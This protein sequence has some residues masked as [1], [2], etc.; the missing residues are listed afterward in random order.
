[1]NYLERKRHNKNKKQL[2]YNT[3]I[4]RFGSYGIKALGF[5]RLEEVTV[6][7]LERL[8]FKNLKSVSKSSETFKVWNSIQINSNNTALSPESR[9]GK[10]K[11][12]LVGRF[13][14]IESGQLLFEFSGTSETQ[15]LF[16]WSQFNS[17]VQ[18]PTK[19]LKS[20]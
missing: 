11:G 9:M 15:A 16:L 14:S 17:K 5:G 6:S 10:G 2:N 20:K 7:A 3:H 12:S 1:M 18:F 19:L 13:A 4:L 8:L